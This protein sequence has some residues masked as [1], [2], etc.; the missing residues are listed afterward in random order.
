MPPR[1][2]TSRTSASTGVRS[3]TGIDEFAGR[4]AVGVGPAQRPHPAR[5][6]GYDVGGRAAHVEQDDVRVLGGHDHG[7]R[8][9]VGCRDLE[10]MGAGLRG[11]AE[12][13]GGV[14]H[15]ASTRRGMPVSSASSTNPT[16]SA[17]VRNRWESSAVMVTAWP[18]PS[19][20]D[21][22]AQALEHDGQP[23]GIVLDRERL[24]ERLD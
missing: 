1:Q 16:P 13:A 12:L 3:G 18:Q 22:A 5:L 24:R 19:R 2:G 7:G 15:H 6:D 9:P 14:E 23:V 21:V 8:R 10:G 4:Q 17:L 11:S 20:P